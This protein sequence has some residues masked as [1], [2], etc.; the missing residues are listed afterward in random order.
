MKNSTDKT[1]DVL[2]QEFFQLLDQ[3]KPKKKKI[4]HE[5]EEQ[6]Q[7]QMYLVNEFVP[8]VDQQDQI[9]F[10]EKSIIEQTVA[11]LNRKKKKPAGST[12]GESLFT[13]EVQMN[14]PM[15]GDI[16]TTTIKNFL[17]VDEFNKKFQYI[18]T[19]IGTLGGGGEVNF[20]MLDDVDR[21]S[22][23]VRGS[24]EHVLQYNPVT[25]KYY[26][27]ELHG[28]HREVNSFTFDE[29]GPGIERTPRMLYYDVSID[30]L[31]LDNEDGTTYH[32]GYD[33]FSRIKN[34]TQNTLT[35]GTFVTNAMV[36]GNGALPATPFIADGSMIPKLSIGVVTKDIASGE[37]GRATKLGRVVGFNTTGSE[38]GETWGVNDI[39][40]AHPTLPGKMTKVQ[41]TAPN[42]ALFIGAVIKVH[43]TDGI[44]T[45]RYTPEP[46]LYY[47]SY[48]DT[49][50]QNCQTINTPTRVRLNTVAYAS[51][52][53]QDANKTQF[54]A[55]NPGLYNFQFSIQFKS[56]SAS[57]AIAYIWYRKGVSGSPSTQANDVDH[58]TTEISIASN[59]EVRV[60]AWNFMVSLHT[61]EYFELMWAVNKTEMYIAAPAATAFCPAVPSVILTVHQ[62]NL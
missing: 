39:L 19:Q 7:E 43:A 18:Q 28:D 49:L 12:I 46:R 2:L 54:I 29:S 51:G 6:Q 26:F 56:T 5:K 31:N 62:V 14:S 45:V 60:A 11:C 44:I 40:W 32:S 25:K 24:D 59:V 30:T 61:G 22:I 50:P 27:G 47:G 33:T 48:Y 53:T 55:Q 41:P 34:T 13:Q 36:T 21:Q 4:L 9:Q 17:T 16:P 8:F 23:D 42:I 10:E 37:Y 15:E 35:T 3:N 38:V 1:S 20:R 58:T 57:A 52:F